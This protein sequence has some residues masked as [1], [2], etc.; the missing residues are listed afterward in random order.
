MTSGIIE[1]LIEDTSV[2][3]LVGRTND[4]SKYRVFAVVAEQSDP[5]Y[6]K[7]IVVFQSSNDAESSLTKDIASELDYPRITVLCVSKVFRTTELLGEAVRRAIDNKESTTDNG[8]VFNRIWLSNE[9]EYYNAEQKM[10]VK[11]QDYKCE[12]KIESLI[13]QFSNAFSN[14]FN[15]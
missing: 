3:D 1:I 12:L 15:N 2:Q 10:F 13:N 4:D 14:A 7:Y 6:D 11:Q 5:V 8:Y 9:Q